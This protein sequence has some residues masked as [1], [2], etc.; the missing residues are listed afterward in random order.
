M[1]NT[2]PKIVRYMRDGSVKLLVTG[3]SKSYVP[4]YGKTKRKRARGKA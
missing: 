3:N 1:K 4:R 2:K